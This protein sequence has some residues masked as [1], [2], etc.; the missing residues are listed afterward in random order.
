VLSLLIYAT[1]V[2]LLVPAEPV[3]RLFEIVFG[4]PDGTRL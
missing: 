2:D 4:E 1:S 3:R